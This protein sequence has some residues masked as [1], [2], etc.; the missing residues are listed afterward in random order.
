VGRASGVA[1]LAIY[2][3]GVLEV[4]V[5]CVARAHG[6]NRRVDA[7]GQMAGTLIANPRISFA[8]SN[9]LRRVADLELHQAAEE[10]YVYEGDDPVPLSELRHRR[11]NGN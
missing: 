4:S 6:G 11:S 8:V 7:L 2:S 3:R 10:M 1:A 9:P 5:R